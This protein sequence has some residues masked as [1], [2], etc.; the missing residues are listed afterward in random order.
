[1]LNYR[2][3]HKLCKI[4]FI[5]CIISNKT[6]LCKIFLHIF[7]QCIIEIFRAEHDS[8]RTISDIIKRTESNSGHKRVQR[9]GLLTKNNI[10]RL[11]VIFNH[12]DGISQYQAARNSTVHNNSFSDVEKHH[13]NQTIQENRHSKAK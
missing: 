2:S 8:D 13:W 9:S 11:K 4:I 10:K 7:L 5:K 6:Y 3:E 12:R 1:M